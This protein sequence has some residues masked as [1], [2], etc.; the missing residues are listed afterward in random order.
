VP[1]KEVTKLCLKEEMNFIKLYQ[2]AFIG[3]SI[4]SYY[5]LENVMP[6]ILEPLS[7]LNQYALNICYNKVES[8]NDNWILNQLFPN[9]L[10]IK[11]QGMVDDWLGLVKSV[12]VEENEIQ[13]M[14]MR[15]IN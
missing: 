11:H 1:I 9:K 7:V 10:L 2:E 8:V 6:F 14:L 13:N 3:V 4:L 12:Q 15:N 5:N